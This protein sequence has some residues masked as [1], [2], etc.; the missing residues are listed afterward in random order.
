LNWFNGFDRNLPFLLFLS[1]LP[2]YKLDSFQ[3]WLVGIFT[4][5]DD[6]YILTSTPYASFTL[7]FTPAATWFCT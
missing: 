3:L 4:I 2:Q 5:H 7:A 6:C 1:W